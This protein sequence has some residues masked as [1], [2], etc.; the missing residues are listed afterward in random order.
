TKTPVGYRLRFYFAD[1]GTWER[2]VPYRFLPTLGD[3]DLHLFNEG[4]HRQ[5]W[6]KLGAHPRVM[7]GVAGVSFAVWAPNARRVSVVGDFCGWDGRVFPMRMMGSSGVW[8][9]FLP[10]IEPGALYKFEMLTR[11]GNIRVK[12][13]P[14]A[15]KM[16]QFPGTASIVER[17]N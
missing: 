11:D 6:T 10:D 15:F 14:V 5:L 8:E 16:E 12:T 1:G 13:D 4:T 3:V 2:E 17:E 7:D 9:I